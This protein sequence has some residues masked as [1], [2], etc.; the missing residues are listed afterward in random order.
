ML[1]ICIFDNLFYCI[2]LLLFY[3]LF[4]FI[5][6]PSS[7]PINYYKYYLF[8]SIVKMQKKKQQCSGL[9][10]TSI[11][12]FAIDIYI[13]K[14]IYIYIFFFQNDHYLII[15]TIAGIFQQLLKKMV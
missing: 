13:Y 2:L 3:C 10:A 14:Y 4:A 12:E 7:C 1:P 6:M 9:S 15:T 5:D 8:G 11:G